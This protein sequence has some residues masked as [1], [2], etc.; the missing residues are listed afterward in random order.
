[1]QTI[2]IFLVLE[3]DLE[4]ED[5]EVE[6]LEVVLIFFVSTVICYNQQYFGV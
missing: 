1:M 5:L 2:Y 4:V 6:D 3:L